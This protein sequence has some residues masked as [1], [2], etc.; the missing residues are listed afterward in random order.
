MPPPRGR[1]GYENVPKPTTEEGKL[2]PTPKPR[3]PK[4]AAGANGGEAPV[5]NAGKKK[6]VPPPKQVGLE[7]IVTWKGIHVGV[8]E[9]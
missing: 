1:R 2:S 9:E 5:S 3:F 8:G 6:P 4:A 7:A